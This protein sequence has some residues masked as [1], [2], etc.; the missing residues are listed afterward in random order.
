[1]EYVP[2]GS[3]Q[4]YLP[5]CKLDMPQSLMFAQ[6]ICQVSSVVYYLIIRLF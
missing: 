6:Q 5:K 4:K 3:L 2:L 1:M